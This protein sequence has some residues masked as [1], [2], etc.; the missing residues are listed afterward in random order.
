MKLNSPLEQVRGLAIGY[1]QYAKN[2]HRQL[3]APQNPD[4][5]MGYPILLS[6]DDETIDL[7]LTLPRQAIP[8]LDR[9]TIESMRQD[10]K[11]L[12]HYLRYRRPNDAVWRHPV[13]ALR[14]HWATLI[15]PS[16]ARDVMVED[17]E[18]AS[19]LQP[20]A[21]KRGWMLD[22]LAFYDASGRWLWWHQAYRSERFLESIPYIEFEP[23]HP[24]AQGMI[25]NTLDY[26]VGDEWQTSTDK[27][28]AVEYLLDWLLWSVGHPLQPQVPEDPWSREKRTFDWVYQLFDTQTLL[29]IPGDH[30]GDMIRRAA[31]D[32]SRPMPA[33]HL[34]QEEANRLAKRLFPQR[35][36]D[37]R[38]RLLVDVQA[39]SGT[40][41]LAAS[42]FTTKLAG[43]NLDPL[44]S[45]AAILNGY[46]Y[47]PWLVLPFPW[48]PDEDDQEWMEA[49]GRTNEIMKVRRVKRD[50][51]SHTEPSGQT[52]FLPIELRTARQQQAQTIPMR[53]LQQTPTRRLPRTNSGPATPLA[54]STS[55]QP[56][57]PP[58]RPALGPGE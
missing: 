5:D 55:S 51:F 6:L 29:L 31:T 53:E 37:Y 2:L 27:W 50:Y 18:K 33:S 7:A 41:L 46:F 16:G 44:L 57:L 56:Q 47:V 54:G 20:S 48:L 26:I 45:K 34:A 23:S 30:L 40:L 8:H 3:S 12:G 21:A 58:Q 24:V 10:T 32:G 36:K 17:L 13:N 35:R 11:A 9:E 42:N 38:D 28:I 22:Y 14:G 19:G 15:S 49:V 25:D 39:N 4:Q 43:T 52:E 1:R